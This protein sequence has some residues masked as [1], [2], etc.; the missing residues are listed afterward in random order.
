M[1]Y[2]S[3]VNKGLRFGGSAST[4]DNVGARINVRCVKKGLNCR[5]NVSVGVK[6]MNS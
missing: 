6:D 1:D 3:C 4:S 5:V 2:V